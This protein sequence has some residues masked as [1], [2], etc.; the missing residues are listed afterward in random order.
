MED[1][2]DSWLNEIPVSFWSCACRIAGKSPARR[3]RDH[4]NCRESAL[5]RV[6]GKNLSFYQ[7]LN[8]VE[9]RTFFNGASRN[10]RNTLSTIG[11][12]IGFEIRARNNFLRSIA[13][14]KWHSNDNITKNIA[15][16]GVRRF[17]RYLS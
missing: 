16:R 5:F 8:H 1:K 15:N 12:C 11:I 13:I 2:G 4:G 17:E 7:S 14:T 10:L 9:R 3:L 6:I